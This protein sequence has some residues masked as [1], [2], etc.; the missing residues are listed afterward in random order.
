MADIPFTNPTPSFSS[1]NPPGTGTGL[2]YI[3]EHV[4]STSGQLAS[5]TSAVTHFDFTTGTGYILGRVTCFGATKLADPAVGRTSLF[6]ISFNGEVVAT[7]KLDTAEEDM[8]TVV[9]T[10]LLLPPFTR[11]QV[12]CTSDSST[13]DRLTSALITGRVYA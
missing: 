12:T 7:L 11:V 8:P 5:N 13:A 3:G 4:Y 10:K 1:S 2:N 6:Q 9:Y